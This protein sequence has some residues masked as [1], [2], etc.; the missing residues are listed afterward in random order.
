MKV[1][2]FIQLPMRQPLG[3]IYI[4]FS[5]IPFVSMGLL[6]STTLW[7]YG[8]IV[9]SAFLINTGWIVFWVVVALQLLYYI[10]RFLV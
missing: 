7:I 4:V 10:F 5:K 3:A 1:K 8:Y 2:Y 9:N 6:V